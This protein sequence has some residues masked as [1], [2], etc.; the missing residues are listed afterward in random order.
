MRNK[1]PNSLRRR[2]RIARCTFVT[3]ILIP[4]AAWSEGC[5]TTEPVVVAR[6]SKP[7]W[8]VVGIGGVFF[9]AEDPDGLQRWYE[10]NFGFHADTD[11]AVR[12]WTREDAPPYMRMY[13]VWSPF[14][15]DTQYFSPSRKPYMLNFQVRGL[16]AML[17]D[18]REQGVTVE[19]NI[20]EYDYGRFA[21]V[22]DPEGTRIELWE[23]TP[24][25][26]PRD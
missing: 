16:D 11:G 4:L 23:P 1:D 25:W 8:R 7:A 21:W 18:L 26:K 24:G 12:F 20:E 9:K 15:R 17:R 3:V 19:P 6:R 2:P 10:E 13:S 5:A 14:R 22:M